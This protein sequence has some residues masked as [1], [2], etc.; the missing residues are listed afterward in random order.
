MTGKRTGSVASC[1]QCMASKISSYNDILASCSDLLIF[2]SV[3][4]SW[5]LL[6]PG[7]LGTVLSS[8]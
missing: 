1:K 7:Y 3:V 6:H 5:Y 2:R 4:Y 8:S